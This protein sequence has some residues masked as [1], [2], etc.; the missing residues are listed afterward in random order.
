MPLLRALLKE[1]IALDA[2]KRSKQ[3]M[4]S[5]A[6]QGFFS[7]GRVPFG[8]ESR[9]VETRGYKEKKKLFIVESEANVVRTIFRLVTIGEGGAPLTSGGVSNWLNTRGYPHR[10]GPFYSGSVASILDREHYTG[11]Y[12]VRTFDNEGK[13]A[14]KDDWVTMECPPIIDQIAFEAAAAVRASRVRRV[15]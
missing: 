6:E 14:A 2:S 8:Y 11:R 1:R 5:N 15:R 9:T 4:R 13:L 3:A 12:R 7:G 10:N